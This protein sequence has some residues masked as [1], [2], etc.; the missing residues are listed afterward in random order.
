M[1][2]LTFTLRNEPPQR[3]DLSALTPDRLAGKSAAEIEAIDIG[4]TRSTIKVGDVFKVETGDVKTTRYEGGSSRFD[5]IGAKLLPGFSIHVEGAVGA[6]LGRLAKGGRITVTGSAGPYVASG[7]L[8]AE[9]EIKGDAGDFLAG[10]LAGELAGMAGGRVIVRGAAGARAGDRLRRGIIV[11]EGDAGED[12]GARL[13]AGTIFV[14][15]KTG[16]RIGYLNKRGSIVLSKGQCFGPTYLDCGAHDLT[17]ARLFARSLKADSPAAAEL[18]SHKLRRYGG[19][20]AVYGKG[21]I[22]TPV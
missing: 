2:G 15:G 16:G 17:F 5:L 13:I 1:T 10:P 4:T 20:T 12:L 8:G 9:I 11:I 6:Q 7:N 19:D 14:L 3:V 21:E 22:L 18:L